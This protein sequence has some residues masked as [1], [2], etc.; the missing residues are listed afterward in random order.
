[1]IRLLL[2]LLI[3]NLGLP[4]FAQQEKKILFSDALSMHLPKYD[5]MAQIAY[6]HRDYIKA[7]HLFDSL[8]NYNLNGSYMDDFSFNKLNGKEISLHN[9]K[10][11]IYLITYASW[12]VT[13]DGEIPAINKLA[14]KYGDQVDFV[15][16]FWDNQKITKKMAKSYNSNI[17]V[18][19][20]NELTN[21]DSYVISKLKHSLGLPTTFLIDTDKKILDIKR[22]VTHAY[23]ISFNESFSLNYDS[24]NDGIT[25]YL[26]GNKR[27]F[28][29]R[30]D[31]VAA[32]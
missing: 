10:K 16:L 30:Q 9:F 26:L 18:V 22:G 6:E 12:C 20:V 29:T 28:G 2:L 27:S 4:A 7:Q 32:N 3:F 23:G 19:Y 15:I 5:K 25:N 14:D 8:I 24:I 13:S 21:K 31:P 1:M 17:K 11:P